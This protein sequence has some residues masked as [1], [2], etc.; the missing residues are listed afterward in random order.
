MINFILKKVSD[1]SPH[2]NLTFMKIVHKRSGE[3]VEEPGDILYTLSL[4][5]ATNKIAHQETNNRLGDNDVSLKTYLTEFYKTYNEV[6]ELLKKT[7]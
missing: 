5:D 7:L 2:Y 3:E 4:Q 1:N 6:C